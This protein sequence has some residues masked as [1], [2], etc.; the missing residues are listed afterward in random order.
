[1]HGTGLLQEKLKFPFTF[2][3]IP[4]SSPINVYSCEQRLKNKPGNGIIRN[5]IN[6]TNIPLKAF[7]LMLQRNLQQ[8][9]CPGTALLKCSNVKVLFQ[10]EGE[11]TVKIYQLKRNYGGIKQSGLH[12]LGVGA[13]LFNPSPSA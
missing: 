10:H 11:Q 3:A 4:G 13:L 2:M 8:I 7:L 1:M 12:S 5:E 6:S 9:C